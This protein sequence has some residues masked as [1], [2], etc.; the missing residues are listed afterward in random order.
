VV[1]LVY[2]SIGDTNGVVYYIGTAGGTKTFANPYPAGIAITESG[3]DTTWSSTGTVDRNTATAWISP[4][5]MPAGGSWVVWDLRSFLLR[6]TNYTIRGRGSYNYHHPRHWR[7]EASNDGI[8]WTTLRT[9]TNDTTLTGSASAG[10]WT[11]TTDTHYRLFRFLQTG[12]GTTS[13][14]NQFSEI[15]FYGNLFVPP[16]RARLTGTGGLS[17]PLEFTFQSHGDANGIIYYRATLNGAA[18]WVNPH[19]SGRMTITASSVNAADYG[20]DQAVDRGTEG[21]RP[22]ATTN[23]PGGWIQFDLGEPFRLTHYAIQGNTEINMHQPR[24]WTVQGSNS[25]TGPWT[26]LDVHVNDATINAEDAWGDWPLPATEA[27]RYVRILNTGPTSTPNNHLLLGEVEFYGTQRAPVEAGAEI[28]LGPADLTAAGTLTADLTVTRTLSAALTAAGAV[29]GT[30]QRATP[31]SGDLAASGTLTGDVTVVPPEPTVHPLAATVTAAGGLTGDVTVVPP[32]PPAPAEQPLTGTVTAAGGITGDL[33]VI[34]A[35]TETALTGT[36]AAVGSLTGTL[37]ITEAPP[38]EPT[39]VPLSSTVAAL[40]TL[41]GAATAE[42]TLTADLDGGAQL[43]GRLALL[44]P[45]EPITL[46]A[47]VTAAATLTGRLTRITPTALEG[48][49]TGPARVH[50]RTGTVGAA[51]RIGVIHL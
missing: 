27:H 1:D 19:T 9:H 39:V 31:L 35:P 40:G 32:E 13:G 33:T 24:S 26:D 34:P 51:N 41:T 5:P 17:E 36:V 6:P 15:D 44:E 4:N 20:I 7:F 14:Y 45:P 38:P 23:T 10:M 47:A 29:T 12:N 30:V 21:E 11:L 50:L 46:A 25:P 43:H 3:H 37:T 22:F 8:T 42:K 18:A 49:V 2:A 48:G 16:M 28:G